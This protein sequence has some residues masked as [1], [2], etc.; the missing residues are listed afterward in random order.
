MSRSKPAVTVNR[1]DDL[2]EQ[3]ITEACRALW[4]AEMVRNC[5][6]LVLGAMAWTLVWLVVDQ[7]IYSP[8]MGSRVV[9]WIMTVAFACWY[10]RNKILPLLRSR[11]HP[12][13][14]A[15][16]L[17]RDLP[18]LR[19]SL[20]SY[21]TLREQP[22]AAGLRSRVVRSI[23]AATAG[24]LKTYDELPTEAT[25]TLRWWI[26]AAA[27]FAVLVAYN[28][29]SPKN[30]FQSAARLAAP[31]AAIDAPRRV[32]IRNVLPGDTDAIAGRAVAV[33]AVIDGLKTSET[34]ICRWRLPSE[35]R[36]AAM[37][38]DEADRRFHGEI[39]VPYSVSGDVPYTIIGGDAQ[40]GPFYLKVEDLPAVALQSVQY[41]PPAYTAQK[42][43]ATSSG[44]ITALDGTEVT[45]TATTNRPIAKAKIEFNPRLLG[46]R[47]QATA[48]ATEMSVDE[49]GTKLTV[50]F[51]LRSAHG[52]SAAVEP[53]SYRIE[54]SDQA[55]Q[56]NPEPIVYPIRVIADLPPEVAITLPFQSPTEV[57]IDAQQIIE[58]HASDPDFGLRSVGLEIRSGIDTIATPVLWKDPSGGRGN[59]VVE[60]AFRPSRYDLR[61]GDEVQVVAVAID[62]RTIEGDPT[63]EPNIT[64]TDPIFLKIAAGDPN[65][66][67]NESQEDRDRQAKNPNQD[68]NQGSQEQSSQGGQQGEPQAGQ[69]GGGSDQDAG[70]QAQSQQPSEASPGQ[71]EGAQNEGS[72]EGESN[73]EGSGGGSSDTSEGSDDSQDSSSSGGQNTA[74]SESGAGSNGGS[75]LQ[76][77]G[78]Q[79]QT[80]DD[81]AAENPSGEDASGDNDTASSDSEG[82]RPASANGTQGS[83]AG[84]GQQQPADAAG[85]NGQGPNTNEAQSSGETQTSDGQAG[86]PSQGNGGGQDSQQ[87]KQAPQHDGEA[88]ERIRDYLEKQRKEQSQS[89]ES[90]GGESQSGESQSGESQSGETQSGETQSGE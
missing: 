66:P 62:N 22:A 72:Q 85:D 42:P 60:F 27:G 39:D 3:R 25:G 31:L 89:G 88:F 1:T 12:E 46:D 43:H 53:D 78:G 55:G 76:E 21:V 74:G 56:T 68:R 38:W 54:V 79:P 2:I 6:R 86:D 9:V 40:A 29:I 77:G 37:R 35:D 90:Q 70:G 16:S 28:A 13:Y 87:S 67:R 32:S 65:R 36:E 64:R 52:R 23:G 49:A 5:L 50:R 41:T 48:G 11:I 26:A 33:S 58:V 47:M 69:G 7:W 71:G 51:V 82:G 57:A 4:W 34:P 30:S 83:D 10:T 75:G 15:R 14:A 80:N 59:Q 44:V 20:T 81:Q 61:I 19:Q 45:I 18:D 73:S 8:G 84:A 63:V 24:R 17:E